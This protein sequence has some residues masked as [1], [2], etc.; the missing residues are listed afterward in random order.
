MRLRWVHIGGEDLSSCS[1]TQRWI[2][3][4]DPISCYTLIKWQRHLKASEWRGCCYL[5]LLCL[6]PRKIKLFLIAFVI[7]KKE[8]CMTILDCAVW[9]FLRYCLLMMKR[10][11][12]VVMTIVGYFLVDKDTDNGYRQTSQFF[13]ALWNTKIVLLYIPAMHVLKWQIC[14]W[15]ICQVYMCAQTCHWFCILKYYEMAKMNV[16]KS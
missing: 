7:P 13:L 4:P 10:C 8:N 3:L 2:V 15:N 12:P 14:N 16:E 9:C 6:S 5:I 1:L 11:Y